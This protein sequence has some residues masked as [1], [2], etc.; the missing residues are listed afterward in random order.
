MYLVIDF[1]WLIKLYGSGCLYWFC[2]FYW[3]N[4]QE[5]ILNNYNFF[6][7]WFSPSEWNGTKCDWLFHHSV[8]IHSQLTKNRRVIVF[9]IISYLKFHT[10]SILRHLK[11]IFDDQAFSVGF[12]W[13][14]RRKKRKKLFSKNHRIGCKQY[15]IELNDSRNKS[16]SF[17]EKGKNMLTIWINICFIEFFFCFRCFAV[18]QLKFRID[19]FF[20]DYLKKKKN[21]LSWKIIHS[22]TGIPNAFTKSHFDCV[23]CW[24]AA[25]NIHMP[26]WNISKICI[27]T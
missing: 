23:A 21:N 12:D 15:I 17:C 8:L 2:V 26:M 6:L 18:A 25:C 16:I 7:Y 14:E 20:C 9:K 27:Y 10:S 19:D 4:R 3:F 11:K 1:F 22:W 13:I 24:T 5:S